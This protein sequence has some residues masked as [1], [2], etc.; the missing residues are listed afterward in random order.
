MDDE[1]MWPACCLNPPTALINS[2]TLLVAHVP[3]IHNTSADVVNGCQNAAKVEHCS[4]TRVAAENKC[5]QERP[6]AKV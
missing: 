2:P 6:R 3:T 1:R 4:S 5:R